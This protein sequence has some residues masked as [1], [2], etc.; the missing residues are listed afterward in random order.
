MLR[1]SQQ[2]PN[3]S[4]NQEVYSSFDFN[5]TSLAPLGTKTLIYDDLASHASWAPHATDG[6][7]VGPTSNHYQCLRFYIPSM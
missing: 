4:V 6:F 3:K 1:F 7:Y 2:N 5:K